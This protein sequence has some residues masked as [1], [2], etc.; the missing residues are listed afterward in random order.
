LDKRGLTPRVALGLDCLRNYQAEYNEDLRVF[1]TTPRH[2]WTSH[3]SDA[4]RYLSVAWKEPMA[5]EEDMIPLERLREDLRRPRTWND[6]YRQ[7][8]DER[9]TNGE[10]LDADEPFNLNDLKME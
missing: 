1:K 9:I 10:E 4:W 7:H 6:V 5:T 8:V 2:D 3:G